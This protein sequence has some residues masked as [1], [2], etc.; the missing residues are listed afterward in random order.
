MSAGPERPYGLLSGLMAAGFV[1]AIP[2]LALDMDVVRW[3][4]AATMM[5]C[6]CWAVVFLR[7]MSA[8]PSSFAPG[9]WAFGLLAAVMLVV[10][11]VEMN[12]SPGTD[13]YG[14]GLVAAGSA[15]AAFGAFRRSRLRRSAG[16]SRPSVRL[17]VDE[18][19]RHR[20][21]RSE[22]GQG[23]DRDAEGHGVGTGSL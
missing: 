16:G 10:G 2:L 17:E 18:G 5:W 1:A 14:I 7:R 21:A 8:P 9:E 11:L 13:G 12:S 19:R 6:A 20:A 3:V 15:L 22:M 23:V 4:A